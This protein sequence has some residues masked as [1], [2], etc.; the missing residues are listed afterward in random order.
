M[1][2]G[3]DRLMNLARFLFRSMAFAAVL[4]TG[5]APL[6]GGLHAQTGKAQ[7]KHGSIPWM[8]SMD[9]A[10]AAAAKQQKLMLVDFTADW[11]LTCKANEAV[12][13]DQAET[14]QF[15]ADNG[16]VTLKADKTQPAP[17]VDELLQKLGNK[18]GSIPF[19]AVFP[20]GHPNQPI[21]LDGLFTSPQPILNALRKGVTA[22]ND[23]QQANVMAVENI[24][25]QRGRVVGAKDKR[26]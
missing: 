15:I 14:R 8:T 22:R 13:I 23:I 7:S 4:T 16:I 2:S 10:K 1:P 5:M 25:V 20:A 17:E 11:C 3:K 6:P 19:Y 18:A 12:A 24:V 26:E 21:V 9:K